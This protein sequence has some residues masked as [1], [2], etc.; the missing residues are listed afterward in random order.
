MESANPSCGGVGG[1]SAGISKR[2]FM[3]PKPS[4]SR[5]FHSG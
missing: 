3:P 2:L 5:Q 4:C 1:S